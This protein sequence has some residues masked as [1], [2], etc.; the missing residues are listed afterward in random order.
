MIS[1][2]VSIAK[3]FTVLLKIPSIPYF[4]NT[5]LIFDLKHKVWYNWQLLSVSIFLFGCGIKVQTKDG[6]ALLNGGFAWVQYM[7]KE[8]QF[9]SLSIGQAVASMY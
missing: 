8:S 9:H 2:L 6:P 7:C 3:N 5:I 1:L 4:V